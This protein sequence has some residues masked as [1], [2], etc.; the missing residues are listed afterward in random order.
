MNFSTYQ[1]KWQNIAKSF[2]MMWEYLDAI[3]KARLNLVMSGR[4]AQFAQTGSFNGNVGH[5]GA[6]DSWKSYSQCDV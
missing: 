2:L 6:N 4:K 3:A 1:A 5:C